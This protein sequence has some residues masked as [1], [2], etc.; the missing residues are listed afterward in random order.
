MPR[1]PEEKLNFWLKVVLLCLAGLAAVYLLADHILPVVLTVCRFVGPLLLPFILAL[2]LAVVLEPLI[3]FLQRGFKLSRTPSVVISLLVAL[4]VIV[5]VIG[6]LVSRLVVEIRDLI[7]DI[8]AGDVAFDLEGI[9][10]WIQNFY[11]T[12]AAD[13]GL[14]V[15]LQEVVGKFSDMGIEFLNG[16][17]DA[18]SST[19]AM[20]FMVLVMAFA[21]YYFCKDKN[22]ALN[23]LL[24]VIPKKHRPQISDTYLSTIDAFLGYFRAQL[25]LMCITCVISLIG[26]TVLRMDYVI[27]MAI[28]IGFFDV[29]PVFGPG[30]IYIPWIILRLV[31]GDIFT[32]VGLGVVYAI[33]SVVRYVLQPKLISD[34]MGLHPLAT[35]TSIF[36]GLRV[37]GVIGILVGPILWV[38]GLAVYRAYR[39][40][41]EKLR[42][43]NALEVVADR[44]DNSKTE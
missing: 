21:T 19:P 15:E 31:A 42:E 1:I 26:L 36:I 30:A 2:I 9:I 18:I 40:S 4:G 32:A 16:V 7:G 8:S 20:L 17:T 39:K 3:D 12:F 10:A 5:F 43:E 14:P 23:F 22:M 13:L 34:E 44:V 24:K 29:L 37:F 6:A 28:L 33:C 25:L 35:I 38:V 41:D 11:H 27:L